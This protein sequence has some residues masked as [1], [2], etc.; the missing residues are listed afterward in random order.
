M[1]NGAID[2]H[3]AVVARVTG[4]ADVAAA[5][6]FAQANALDVTVRGGGH[7]TAGSAVRD[8]ELARRRQGPAPGTGRG[9][10]RAPP[11]S[12]G[13]RVG[14]DDCGELRGDDA[15]EEGLRRGGAAPSTRRRARTAARRRALIASRFGSRVVPA[16]VR[17]EALDERVAGAPDLDCRRAPG[18]ARRA[19]RRAGTGAAAAARRARSAG[20]RRRR[21]SSR[22][23]T[24]AVRVSARREGPGE[25]ERDE[26][27]VGEE[28]AALGRP[29][30]PQR[31][32]ETTRCA[33]E[34]AAAQT[35]AATKASRNR[36]NNG[37]QYCGLE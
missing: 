21:P 15:G 20:R 28:R 3:P 31:S 26:R 34:R 16:P 11:R 35:A 29:P 27:E 7:S 17:A 32:P 14:E 2:R 30:D 18:R 33:D 23:S 37:H 10:P 4:P 9:P 19:R 1:F 6:A 36:S 22:A 24:L 13:A 12:P 25:R 8:G 5:L